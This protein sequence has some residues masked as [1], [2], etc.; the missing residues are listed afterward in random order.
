MG[1]LPSSRLTKILQEKAELLKKRRQGAEAQAQLAE[2]RMAQL[3]AVGIDPPEAEARD[4]SLRELIR[5]SDWEGVDTGA[6]TFLAYLEREAGPPLE[7]RR[8][9]LAERIGRVAATE[10]PVAPDVA[11]LVE[12]SREHQESGRWKEA[13]EQLST[14]LEAVREAETQYIGS[15]GAR[16]RRVA[17]WA[18]E[19]EDHLT[20]AL[21]QLRPAFDAALSGSPE[22]LESALRAEAD[23][24]LPAIGARLNSESSE[25][26]A[27]L[28]A[29]RELALPAEPAERAL[30]EL[31]SAS[32]FNAPEVSA[33]LAEALTQVV[34]AVRG[35]VRATLEGYRELLGS[36]RE[37]GLDPTG[38][39]A[40]LEELAGSIDEVSPAELPHRL[41]EARSVVEEPVVA[42]VAGVL[43]E[44][45]PKLVEVR[46]LGR[47]SS[48]VFSAMNRAREAL[49][50]RLYGE[51][52]A[53]SQEALDR[54]TTLTEDLE[55]ARDEL[56]T[57][58]ELLERLAGAQF[59]VADFAPVLAE[60]HGHLDRI[61]LPAAEKRLQEVVE[62]IGAAAVQHFRSQLSELERMGQQAVEGGFAP[63]DFSARLEAVRSRLAEG[64]I[65][66]V[67]ESIARL[68]VELRSA[69]QPY[70]ARR[71]EEIQRSLEEIPDGSLVDPVRRLL[72][73]TEVHLRVKED[74]RGALE[75]L[76]RA[77]REFSVVSAQHASTLVDGLEEERRV[78]EAMGGAGDDMQRQIDEVQQIFNMGDFVKAFRAAQEIRT[79]AHQQ[80]LVRSEEAISHAK[81]ALVEL[82]KIGLDTAAL[83]TVLER[84]QQAAKDGLYPEAYR[85]AGQAFESAQRLKTTAQAILD[86]IREVTDLWESL[87]A[88]GIEVAPY[89]EQ[90]AQARAACERLE[91]DRARALVDELHGQ[92]DR[93]Q[94]RFEA[95][96]LL[97]QVKSLL[98]DAR[99]LNV[100]VEAYPARV[101]E[102]ARALKAAP[103]GELWSRARSLHGELVG[104]MR[105]VLEENVR[106]LERD[107]EI[108]RGVELDVGPALETITELRH[109]LSAPVPLGMAELLETARARF[110]ETK[111]FVEHAER[112]LRRTREALSRAE[113]VRVDVRPFRT[114]YE[115]IERHLGARDFARVIEQA[116]TLERELGQAT[117]QQV[118]KTLA[119]FQG[120]VSRARGEKAQTTLAENLLEQARHALER[121]EPLEALQLAAQSEAELERAEL[122]LRVAESSLET[123]EHRLEAS[124]RSGL[125]A[126]AARDTLAL[127]RAAFGAREFPRVL[128]LALQASEALATASEEERRGREALELAERSVRE[129]GDMS[130]DLQDVLPGLERARE[131]LRAGDYPGAVRQ[132]RE[133][134]EAA[135]WSIERMYAGPLAE[136]GEI[137]ELVRSAGTEEEAQATRAARDEAEAA[138]KI[139]EWKRATEALA[140]GRHRAY[141]ALD[142]AVATALG[143]VEQVYA[144]AP[145][146][147]P[148]ESAHRATVGQKLVDYR[149]QHDYLGAL[150]LLREEESRARERLR[151]DLAARVAALQDR[152]W[153]GEKIGVDTTP[154]MEL[155]SEAKLAMEAGR[156]EPVPRLV[157]QGLA[158]LEEL[159]RHRLEEK[160]REVET[161]LIFAREGLHV[162][163][164]TL[165][166]DVENAR[167]ELVSGRPVEA[168]R[169]LLDAWDELNRRK[170]LHR[171]LTNL[172]FLVDAALGR[173]YERHLDT[174]EAR[175]LLEE[176]LKL[177]STDYAPALEKARE[178]LRLLQDAL[179]RG[180]PEGYS[181]GAR[182]TGST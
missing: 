38:P 128:E 46:R 166:D 132:A 115:R 175:R 169:H 59:P 45:R 4:A 105:P 172:H 101:T 125:V 137:V 109:R 84:G 135:R 152:L 182:A 159:V 180:A 67:A 70:L 21:A 120:L 24:E 124:A 140:A 75:Q 44:V 18:G 178:A 16:L 167:H 112:A 19:S 98:E 144:L 79:R 60:I 58:D 102:I 12:A 121:S 54:A 155:F 20:L 14:V 88:S 148:E 81:L 50:L 122:Q 39:L 69:A 170:A 43:D 9:E 156:L 87:K 95:Q 33:K 136:L 17:E 76:R 174:G 80:Q 171:E 173:A 165:P 1:S 89:S 86:R 7:A 66:A 123:I 41:S 40:R 147:G 15:L 51:A 153:I 157:S 6:R 119:T 68:H 118:A 85:T 160:L 96:R 162:T 93:E 90:I 176:S 36:L 97:A 73:D 168:G 143:L 141:Q 99:K 10:H 23:R 77:E 55:A 149:S 100:P 65:P 32:I 28:G 63:A 150:D 8:R 139:R 133:A 146:V 47:N 71:L 145:E 26:E 131:L 142:R 106:G 78:L 103:T 114:R 161:E 52:V 57:V 107:V 35:R 48:E 34:E 179:S 104:V 116:S 130:A 53:A 64:D 13:T 164:G 29:A 56:R 25:A 134:G 138:V 61:E 154:V 108:A 49:R 83:K 3:H 129:A 37:G 110:F 74:L 117:H 30:A 163:V 27:L 62:Q 158:S 177:R 82:G 94:A 111:G 42:V 113:I 2:E 5:H 151:S 72:A 92:L 31:R 127:A 22:E 126:P 11:A 181:P 91:F